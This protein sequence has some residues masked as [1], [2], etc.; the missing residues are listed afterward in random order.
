MVW[1]VH[2][3]KMLGHHVSYSPRLVNCAR[4]YYGKDDGGLFVLIKHFTQSHTAL[5]DQQ[6]HRVLVVLGQLLKQGH[7][8]FFRMFLRYC[9]D[10]VL[11]RKLSYV[12]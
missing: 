9:R 7:D 6:A 1:E 4:A 10:K 8:F 3:D 12:S 5:D 2:L 11:E